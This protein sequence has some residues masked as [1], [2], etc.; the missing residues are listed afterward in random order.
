MNVSTKP[1]TV[2]GL[3]AH[4]QACAG[5]DKQHAAFADARIVCLA[6]DVTAVEACAI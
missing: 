2:R 5:K 1:R 4:Y 6:I 3:F